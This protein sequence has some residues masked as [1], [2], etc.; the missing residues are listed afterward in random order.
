MLS[1][2]FY[3]LVK[4]SAHTRTPHA[5]THVYTQLALGAYQSLGLSFFLPGH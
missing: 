3:T 4:T 5:D 2:E 1:D